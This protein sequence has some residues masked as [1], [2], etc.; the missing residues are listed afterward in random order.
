[1]KKIIAVG[2]GK[3]GVGKS[4]AAVNIA[5]ALANQAYEGAKPL[6]IALVDVDF[7]GPSVPTLM[8][9]KLDGTE[10]KV[11]HQEKFIAPMAHGVKYISI[12]FFL[13]KND[14]PI[15]WRGPM[16]GKAIA[17]LFQDVS[18]GEVDICIVDMPPGTGDAQLSL[19]QGIKLA[20]AVLVTTPQ[21]VALSDVRRALNMFKKVEVPVLGVVENMSGFTLPNGETL[22]IFGKG[23]GQ[24]LSQQYGVRFLGD[25]PL[26]V[27]VREG[28]D[29][30]RPCVLDENSQAGKAFGVIAKNILDELERSGTQ[31]VVIE[32]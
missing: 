31:S 24:T 2:S 1:M 22:N 27:G 13:K 15:I 10:L 18:W 8:G 21:E 17:Q 11:D 23:G 19:A 4:T 29:V 30:G 7:Y 20:G 32:D 3:G 14:D 28:G 6:K 16:F 12:A 9:A 5:V 25:V 26:E